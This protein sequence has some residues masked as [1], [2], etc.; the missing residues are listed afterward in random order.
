MACCLVGVH[1][2][3]WVFLRCMEYTKVFTLEKWG[4]S[5][6][7]DCYCRF[8]PEHHVYRR[9]KNDFKKDERVTDLPHPRLSPGEV[10]NQV[11]EIPKYKDN[12]KACIIKG[13]G[14]TH[15]WTKI[16]MF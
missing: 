12:G 16:R 11:C 4:K 3:K 5:S 2:E 1:M 9:N 6:W 7:F 13:Y 8:L 10:W 14:V 15:N